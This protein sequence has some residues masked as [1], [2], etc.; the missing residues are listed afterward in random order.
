MKDASRGIMFSIFTL[1]FFKR[2][3]LFL[4]LVLIYAMESLFSNKIVYYRIEKSEGNETL[5]PLLSL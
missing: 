2:L 1:S 5:A 3:L 4:P